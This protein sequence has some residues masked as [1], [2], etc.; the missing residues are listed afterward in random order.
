MDTVEFGDLVQKQSGAPCGSLWLLLKLVNSEV[1]S[2]TGLGDWLTLPSHITMDS[3]FP[4]TGL[5]HLI[6]WCSDLERIK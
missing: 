5:A 2:M 6:R 4:T 3:F 1:T